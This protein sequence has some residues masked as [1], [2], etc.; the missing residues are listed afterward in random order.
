M[1][2]AYCKYLEVL[3]KTKEDRSLTTDERETLVKKAYA[4]YKEVENAIE[5]EDIKRIEIV[6]IQMQESLDNFVA[7]QQKQL[8]EFEEML[9]EFDI[10]K[11]QEK[12][13]EQK[14][15]FDFSNELQDLVY[16]TKKGFNE[17]QDIMLTIKTKEADKVKFDSEAF[18]REMESQEGMEDTP[19]Q[20][21]DFEDYEQMSERKL[22]GGI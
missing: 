6:E 2:E 21:E 14:N 8:K 22:R 19:M 15:N 3:Y 7:I 4:E 17:L 1:K 20:F 10:N 12:L 18:I 16:E 13:E 9:K 11:V 5:E